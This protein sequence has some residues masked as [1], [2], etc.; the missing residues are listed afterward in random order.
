MQQD[1]LHILEL[2]DMCSDM[3]FAAGFNRDL[4]QDQAAIIYQRKAAE[5]YQ[6]LQVRLGVVTQE[7]TGPKSLEIPI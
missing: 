4:G 2:Q 1:F 5:L 3:Y 6:I 7:M